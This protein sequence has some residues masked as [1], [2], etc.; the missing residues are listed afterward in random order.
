[1]LET[2]SPTSIRLLC[3]FEEMIAMVTVRVVRE[4]FCWKQKML[5]DVKKKR[6]EQTEQAELLLIAVVNNLR[7][8]PVV[9]SVCQKVK[10]NGSAENLLIGHG[11]RTSQRKSGAREHQIQPRPA[12]SLIAPTPPPLSNHARHP[13]SGSYFR[14]P[15]RTHQPGFASHFLC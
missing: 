5:I 3:R 7:S 8:A 10:P 15:Q 14:I 9:T 2:S 12:V 6:N 4:E 11:C 13:K 1:M